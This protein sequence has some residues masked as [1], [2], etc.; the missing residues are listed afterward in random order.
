MNSKVRNYFIGLVFII[1]SINSNLLAQIPSDIIYAIKTGNTSKLITFF[2]EEVEL[3]INEKEGNYSLAQAEV[4]LKEFFS[5]N[6]PESFEIK[7]DGTQGELNF[8]VGELLTNNGKY[9]TYIYSKIVNN[10]KHIYQLRF[11]Q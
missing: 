2:Y 11:E 7:H 4:V 1:L 10:K 9:R 6:K 8:I 5:K 3:A